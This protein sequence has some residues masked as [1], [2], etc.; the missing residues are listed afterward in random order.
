MEGIKFDSCSWF[1]FLQHA[2]WIIFENFVYCDVGSKERIK[3]KTASVVMHVC[4]SCSH[5][6]YFVKIAEDKLIEAN[7]S[8]ASTR[9]SRL[10]KPKVKATKIH[11]T[12]EM[13]TL[14]E[15]L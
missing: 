7:L 10:L 13:I 6:I 2:C 3:V 8:R 4:Y 11:N 9:L 5:L 12:P 14:L 15:P 1:C